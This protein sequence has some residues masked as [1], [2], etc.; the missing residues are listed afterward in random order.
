MIDLEDAEGIIILGICLHFAGING[1]ALH[2]IHTVHSLM[3][4]GMKNATARGKLTLPLPIVGTDLK[5]QQWLCHAGI[6]WELKISA[7]FC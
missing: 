5:D 2:S 4:G 6:D 1:E 7:R 3:E